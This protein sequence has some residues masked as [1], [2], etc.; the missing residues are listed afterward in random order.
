MGKALSNDH[1]ILLPRP[2][3]DLILQLFDILIFYRHFLDFF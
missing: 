3:K 2:D 1:H